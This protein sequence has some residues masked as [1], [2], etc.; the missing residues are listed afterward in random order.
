MPWQLQKYARK[1]RNIFDPDGDFA[2]L[3]EV[4]EDTPAERA[5]QTPAAWRLASEDER[6]RPSSYGGACLPDQ[7]SV[8]P[9]AAEDGV[10]SG[11]RP[12]RNEL[13]KPSRPAINGTSRAI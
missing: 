12:I 1:R 10:M 5:E 8:I 2:W 3:A 7:P 9:S 11:S 4:C 6:A 13:S